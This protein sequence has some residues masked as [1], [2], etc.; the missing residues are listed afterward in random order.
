MHPDTQPWA[1]ETITGQ[2][3]VPID[4]VGTPAAPPKPSRGRACA[5][6]AGALWISAGGAYFVLEAIAAARFRPYYSYAHDYI[7]DLGVTTPGMLHGRTVD[8]PL[9]YLMNTAF[10]V[11]GS[12]FLLGALL[13]ACAVRPTRAGPLVGFAAMNAVGNIAVGTIHSGPAA[14]VAGIAW[15]HGAGAVAAIAGGNLAIL[16]GS[17][18]VR[19]TGAAQWYCAVSIGLAAVG[20]L[21]FTMLAIDVKTAA[22]GPPLLGVW[23]RGGV[24]SI[25]AWQMLTGGHLI[26]RLPAGQMRE[27]VNP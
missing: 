16:A 1:F 15:L 23:E 10:Y 2:K 9:A 6:A 14:E 22:G 13:V 19:K 18:A 8:S 3:G 21:S 4:D 26:C 5:I 24:Y 20:L 12:F 17:A 27:P 11:Q 25:I 7:S